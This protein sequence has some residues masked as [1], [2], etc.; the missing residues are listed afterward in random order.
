MFG[1]ESAAA[2]RASARKRS[3]RSGSPATV[4]SEHLDRD[5]AAEPRVARAIDLAHPAG[6]DPV[7]DLVVPERLEHANGDDYT[8]GV[9]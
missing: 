3:R 9:A 6:A 5:R 2:A 8:D 1:C 4:G 7:E